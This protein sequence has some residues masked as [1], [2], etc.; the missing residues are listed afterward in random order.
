MNQLVRVV[1]ELSTARDLA[2]VQRIVRSAARRLTGADGATFVLRDGDDCH[3][4]DE[5]AI[6]PLWKGRR[7]PM[8][9]CVSG[10]V[11]RNG[12][13][14][15]IEDVFA[16]PRVPHA[17]Y[18]P[19]FVKSMAM[20][21][22]RSSAPVG[23]IGNYWAARHRPS[24]REVR[25]LQ[26]LADSVSLALENIRLIGELEA[27]VQESQAA[28]ASLRRMEQQLTQAQRM[29]AIGTLA[30]GIAHDYNNL[31]TVITLNCLA[32]SADL[33]SGHAIQD[34]LEEICSAARRATVLT[35]QLLTFSRQQAYNPQVVSLNAV[36]TG[37]ERMLRRL[38]GGNIEL[39][40]R[41]AAD[42][43]PVRIDVP[44]FEQVILNLAFNARDA[45]PQG[46][47]LVIETLRLFL[48]DEGAKEHFEAR[49]GHFVVLA[50]A[51]TG[52]GMDAETQARVFEPFFTTK[53]SGKG[54]GLGLSMAYG[55]VKKCGGFIGVESRPAHGTV[56]KIFLPPA[57]EASPPATAGARG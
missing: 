16:D 23:A 1:Q 21:P 28:L 6:A 30:G 34:D 48:D 22:I 29:D 4:A 41:P 31:L 40:F 33:P 7:F 36:A 15:V 25:V 49:P 53:A 3:Y 39:T 17:A 27:Q 46:G 51:D 11:M 50:V 56:F 24:R 10:W 2:T 5:D 14:A 54:T 37:V 43:A 19:T 32:A 47:R 55:I 35:K 45:M 9:H 52:V 57:A 8:E 20:V 42:L 38:M 26:A 13:P 12:A 44:Q 18:R